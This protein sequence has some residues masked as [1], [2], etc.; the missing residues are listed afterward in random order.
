MKQRIQTVGWLAAFLAL[1]LLWVSPAMATDYELYIAGTQVTDANC[2]NLKDIAGVTVAEGGV[3]QYDPATK[4]L[5]MKEVTV[6]VGEGENAIKNSGVEGLKIDVSGINSLKATDVN[7]STLL[8]F[9]STEIGGNGRLTVTSDNSA[10][11]FVNGT[12]LTISDITLEVSGEWGV[13]GDSWTPKYGTLILKNATVNATSRL[14]GIIDFVA[15]TTENCKIVVPEGGHFDE[16]KHAVVDAEGNKAKEVKIEP[17]IELY[18]AGTQVTD[19][20]CNNLKDI[21]GVTVA[22]GGVFQ[23]DPATKTLTMKEVTVTVGEGENAIKNSGVEGLK[24]DVSGINSLKATDV[25][26]STLLCFASTEIGG[27]GRL[28]VTSD[29]SAGVFVNG[30]TLTISDITLEV[31][32]EWGVKGDS[33]TPKYGTLILKNATVNATSRLG[34]IIDFVA[35]TTENCKIVVPE[36]GHFDEA[37][38]A[39]VDAD[40]NKAKEVKIEPPI[41]LYIA[42]TQVTSANCNNLKDIAGVTVDEGGVFQ[43]DPATKTLTMKEVTV[44]VGEGKNAIKNSGIEGL[45]I[46]V[47]GT[48][49]IE[50]KDWYT[51]NCSA[52][53]ELEGNGSLTIGGSNTIAVYVKDMLTISG[54]TLVASSRYGISGSS[55]ISGESLILKNAKVTAKG[56]EAG[57]ANLASFTT[58]NCKIVVPEGGKFNIPQYAVVDADGNIAKEVKIEPIIELY[59]A[60]TQVTYANC[61][62]LK[63]IAEVTVGTEGEFKYD[64]ATKTLTMKEV[65]VSGGDNKTAIENKGV[66]GLK[67]DVSGTNSLEATNWNTLDCSASTELKGNGSLTIDGSNSIAVYVKKMLTIS[68]ITLVASSRLGIAGENGIDGETLILKNAK[69]TAKGTEAGI[70]NLASFTTENCKII[71]PE[72]GHFDETKYA[73]VDAEGNEAKEVEIGKEAESVTVTGVTVTPTTAEL[74]VSET[75]QLSVAVEPATATNKNYTCESDKESVA[76]VDNTGLITAV[77]VGTATITVTT[78]DGGHTATC[79]LTVT[80]GD[81]PLTGLKVNP[82]ETHIAV[83]QTLSLNV[84]Y[85]PASTTHKGVKWATSDAAIVTVDQSGIIKGIAVGEAI[86]TVK[87]KEDETIKGTCRVIVDPATTI[88]DAAFAGVMIVPNPFDNQLRIVNG[89]LRGEYALLNAQGVMVRSGNMTGNEVMIETTDLTSG[90][91]LLRLTATNGATKVVTVV[92]E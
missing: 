3:F 79:S 72:G 37:K 88:E 5:T 7:N 53:T 70:A 28:T 64:P 91:Y 43:Y 30:T 6:T 25:N 23:Y 17:P 76:T 24:I 54:I 63:D 58:E 14:G 2:N 68:D 20:N 32:G 74:K 50:T 61:N 82:S 67:I 65:T 35:L 84:S 9:A 4:T 21:A 39:V 44:S 46:D 71:S 81:V 73:V 15:L 89:D 10:G 75:K 16:A 12:T 27:N 48:N 41:E 1:A 22:E 62:N 40:G 42:G 66:E 78:E 60:G 19:A 59:I 36:G 90:L 38:H 26:N 33:W 18:I 57:I 29:N 52:S 31:S 13:K 77:G 83:E 92:K 87:S 11:V 47:S 49:S 51:L 86:I 34:G 56:T 55:G 45:K 8:C 80:A 85:E 69:V